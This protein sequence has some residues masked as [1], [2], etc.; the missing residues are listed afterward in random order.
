MEHMRDY[1]I[2]TSF[3]LKKIA[4]EFRKIFEL[5]LPFL[6]TRHNEVHTF[7]V[8]Q[9]ALLLLEK[10][11]GT[12]DVAIPASILH[13]VGWSA[14]PEEKQLEAFGPAITDHKLRRKHEVE[15]VAI[16][17]KILRDLSYD[18]NLISKI[19]TIIDGH[20]TTRDAKSVDDAIV[21]DADKLFRLS[22]LGFRIDA[23][24]FNVVEPLNWI[25][26]L[27]G[28]IE[29]WFLTKTGEEMAWHEALMREEKIVS[30]KK[31]GSKR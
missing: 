8:Y 21:K 7:I 31:E 6:K 30:A 1:V 5:S 18:P 2:D 24:R 16:A 9:Y 22:D 20:D 4:P 23:D 25:R 17:S 29:K 19:V 10:E 3:D 27:R 15:G 12:R 28:Q 13:D 14:V 26:H 11:P